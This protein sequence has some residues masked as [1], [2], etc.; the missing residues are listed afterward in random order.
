MGGVAALV[1]RCA[2]STAIP[3]AGSMAPS[4]ATEAPETWSTVIV[5]SAVPPGAVTEEWEVGSLVVAAAG[6]GGAPAMC[7]C[8]ALTTGHVGGGGSGGCMSSSD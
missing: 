4:A 5:P 7:V 2:K 6:C 8:G 1:L 3:V